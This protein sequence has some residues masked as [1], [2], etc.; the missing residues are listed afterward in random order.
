MLGDPKFRGHMQDQM[1]GGR[2]IILQWILEEEIVRTRAGRVALSFTQ[3]A[4]SY[5]RS[6]MCRCRA[7]VENLFTSLRFV[8][9]E[10]RD[11][12]HAS[13]SVCLSQFLS[14]KDDI[15]RMPTSEIVLLLL[16]TDYMSHLCVSTPQLFTHVS[17]CASQ[18]NIP[19]TIKADLTAVHNRGSENKFHHSHDTAN[20]ST[21]QRPLDCNCCSVSQ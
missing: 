16:N 3:W 7:E 11:L 1:I 21:E 2:R 4:Y 8:G 13:M 17:F 20:N 14:Y 9:F 19:I 10:R 5:A 18:S 6:I 12:L 15:W